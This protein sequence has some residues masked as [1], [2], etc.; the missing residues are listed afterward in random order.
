MN[1]SRPSLDKPPLAVSPRRLRSRRVIHSVS[2][3]AQKPPPAP[4]PKQSLRLRRS[5]AGE[6]SPPTLH[7]EQISQELQALAQRAK[8]DFITTDSVTKIAAGPRS[9][10]LER[11]RLYDVYS[12]RRNERL[13]RKMDE[14]FEAMPPLPFT[15]DPDLGKRKTAKKTELQRKSMPESFF[16]GPASR[17]R[18]SIKPSKI[19]SFVL[20]TSIKFELGGQIPSST[21]R[22]T[23]R[24]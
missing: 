16:S 19:P 2:A 11:G 7:Y 21:L 9:P 13:K 18:S 5:C 6:E 8:N 10:F 12:A 1:R 3:S 17:L 20:R 22:S 23:R 24:K 15:G 14:T 4:S